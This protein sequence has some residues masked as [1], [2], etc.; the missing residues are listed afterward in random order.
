[1]AHEDHFNELV[2]DFIGKPSDTGLFS[3]GPSETNFNMDVISADGKM[4][5]LR[6]CLLTHTTT[7]HGFETPSP[8][9][10]Q[11]RICA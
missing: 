10:I 5:S 9:H 11:I 3:K 7:S 2:N 4:A 6:L 1:M 8:R